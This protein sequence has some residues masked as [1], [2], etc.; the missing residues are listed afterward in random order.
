[1]VFGICG[2]LVEATVTL[3]ELEVELCLECKLASETRSLGL[4]EEPLAEL[5]TPT[6]TA[7]P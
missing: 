3:A 2:S 5:P 7:E 1:M 4:L 6:V